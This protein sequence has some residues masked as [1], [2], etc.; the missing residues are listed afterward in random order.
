MFVCFSGVASAAPVSSFLID[1]NTF[2]QPFA[3]N[4]DSTTGENITRFQMDLTG[5]GTVFDTISGGLPNTTI[6][7]PFTPTGGSDAITG[8]SSFSVSDGG[9]ILDIFFTDFNV[10][11]SFTW[12][13][14]LDFN[15][16]P[17][18]VLGSDLIGTSIFVD[19][20]DGQRLFGNLTAVIGN[21][22]AS[23]FSVTGSTIIPNNVPEPQVIWLLSMGLISFFRVRKNFQK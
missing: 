15:P 23:Q 14:D 20:S 2:T 16:T 21:S 11:E 18:T 22:D 3:L 8:L 5:T 17:S 10:A 7:V 4:N 12:D 13:I 19:F 1:G 9:S 6:G